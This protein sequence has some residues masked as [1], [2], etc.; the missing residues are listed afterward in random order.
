LPNVPRGTI[1]GKKFTL[2][3]DELWLHTLAQKNR[4][5]ITDIQ[6][7][8]ISHYVELLKEWNKSVNLVSRKDVDGIWLNHILLSLSFLFRVEFTPG[9]KILDLGT[10]GGL[11]GIPL[12]I[13][14]N[15]ITFILLDSIRKKTKAVENMVTSLGLTNVSVV[16]SRAEDLNRDSKYANT[17]DAVIAR[18]VS[19][20]ENLVAWGMPFLKRSVSSGTS[21]T[22]S[23]KIVPSDTPVL[24]TMK[25]GNTE[26][27]IEKTLRRFP[28]VKID[29]MDLIFEGSELLQNS[30][31]KLIVVQNVTR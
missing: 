21:P 1:Q 23:K 4:V 3:K 12:G 17:F 25:G 29:S 11:P 31:K 10:G 30:D 26:L 13:V 6:L 7:H 14:R 19:G 2:T 5:V 28:G 27:E 8:K 20:L 15:D 18:A 22:I 9:S 16:C 24:I